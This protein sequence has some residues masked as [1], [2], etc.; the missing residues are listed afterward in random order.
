M[1]RLLKNTTIFL[2]LVLIVLSAYTWGSNKEDVRSLTY[3]DFCQM[4]EE[5]Q[6]REVSIS[7][8]YEAGRYTVNGTTV[9]GEEESIMPYGIAAFSSVIWRSES[10][11]VKPL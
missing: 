5:G 4:V 3:S 11:V 10:A 1:N 2:L 9:S 8:D 6:V 7:A